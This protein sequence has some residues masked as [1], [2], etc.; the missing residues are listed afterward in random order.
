MKKIKKCLLLLVNG[1]CQR[2]DQIT[3]NDLMTYDK[4]LI[5]K[6]VEWTHLYQL[7]FVF[8]SVNI[9][10]RTGRN[11]TIGSY[12]LFFSFR[13]QSI[14]DFTNFFYHYR[15]YSISS[16]KFHTLC[17]TLANLVYLNKSTYLE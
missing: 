8:R 15:K 14:L 11:S 10:R 1:S 9:N 6:C 12:S 13:T 16:I 2:F 4:D 5:V 17:Q 3:I 7:H